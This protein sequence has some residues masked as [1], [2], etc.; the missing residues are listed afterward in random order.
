MSLDEYENLHPTILVCPDC[1]RGDE[2]RCIETIKV[3]RRLGEVTP[4]HTEHLDLVE[5]EGGGVY[6]DFDEIG[7]GCNNCGWRHIDPLWKAFLKRKDEVV[8]ESS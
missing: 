2:L 5:Q 8:N 3:E 7:V 4:L 1:G 6:G